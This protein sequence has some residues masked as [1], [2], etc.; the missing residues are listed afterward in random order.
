MPEH[1][2]TPDDDELVPDL[3]VM[4]MLVGHA[5]WFWTVGTLRRSKRKDQGFQRH[6]RAA[7]NL[8]S[9]M[10]DVQGPSRGVQAGHTSVNFGTNVSRSIHF[11]V[12][13]RSPVCPGKFPNF[14]C[15]VPVMV[16]ADKYHNLTVILNFHDQGT[17]SCVKKGKSRSKAFITHRPLTALALALL[18]VLRPEASY[19]SFEEGVEASSPAKQQARILSFQI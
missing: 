7:G 19:L 17:L 12:T 11:E 15:V 4:I 10:I 14:H 9:R 3:C 8:Q 2:R 16:L 1:Q 5:F 6:E 18:L 13:N